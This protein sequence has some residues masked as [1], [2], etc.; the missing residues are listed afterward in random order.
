MTEI[1]DEDL[2][3]ILAEHSEQSRDVDEAVGICKGA[4]DVIK[5]REA[6]LQ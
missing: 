3:E 4:G 2:E 1:S 5:V 6:K